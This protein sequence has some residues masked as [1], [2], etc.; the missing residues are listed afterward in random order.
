MEPS[1][2]NMSMPAKNAEFS[3][4]FHLMLMASDLHPL[5][6]MPILK[7]FFV[8]CLIFQSVFGTIG[9]LLVRFLMAI[10]R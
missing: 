4:T 5:D 6:E 2:V 3:E 8:F 1:A 10:M 9:S 7:W